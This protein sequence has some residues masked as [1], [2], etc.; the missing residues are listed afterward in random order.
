MSRFAVTTPI[1]YVNDVPHLGT[2]YTTVCADAVR[3]VHALMGDDTILLTG[4][5]EHGIKIQLQATEKGM[6]P[7][8]FVDEASA[9][10][11]AAWPELLVTPDHFIRTTN[12]EHKTFVTNLAAMEELA[13][14]APEG[15]LLVGESGIDS[16]AD[17]LRLERSGVRCFLVGE[18][19]MRQHDVAAAT[20][21][22]LG[23]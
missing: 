2:A 16:H 17:L 7:Q 3:R 19:L 10:F 21:N 18:S 20:R 1:Y 9:S 11:R 13:P 12:P 23:N 8:A 14:L 4:T 5:D 6:M 22:L 15:A